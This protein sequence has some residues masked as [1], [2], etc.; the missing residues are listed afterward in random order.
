M[1]KDVKPGDYSM[2][3]YNISFILC[4]LYSPPVKFSNLSDK[5]SSFL[6]KHCHPKPTE[7]L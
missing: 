3:L 5:L 2:L 6:R 1:F 7:L 4:P